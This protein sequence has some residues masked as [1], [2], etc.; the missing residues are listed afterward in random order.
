[1][2]LNFIYSSCLF[3]GDREG[4][5]AEQ[6]QQQ[7]PINFT[8][9]GGKN[10]FPEVQKMVLD[11]SFAAIPAKFLIYLQDSCPESQEKWDWEKSCRKYPHGSKA[12]PVPNKGW[13]FLSQDMVAGK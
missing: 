12:D 7:F 2:F 11:G 8:V 3:C 9:L 6:P 10:S 4:H 13:C 5:E 1:M